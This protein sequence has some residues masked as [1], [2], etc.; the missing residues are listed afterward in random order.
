MASAIRIVH[1]YTQLVQVNS[2]LAELGMYV[3]S[4]RGVCVVA[5]TGSA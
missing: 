4:V 5:L 1:T 2:I 3:R